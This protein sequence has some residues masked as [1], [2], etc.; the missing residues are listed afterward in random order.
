MEIG[1]PFQGLFTA[2]SNTV[3]SAGSAVLGG[4]TGYASGVIRPQ[5]GSPVLQNVT[6]Q[7]AQPK[8]SNVGTASTASNGFIANS[9]SILQRAG[10]SVTSA[11]DRIKTNV[12]NGIQSYELKKKQATFGNNVLTM[13]YNAVETVIGSG[14]DNLVKRL[15]GGGDNENPIPLRT[16]ETG[17]ITNPGPAVLEEK[18]GWFPSISD[19]L[20]L[21]TPSATQSGETVVIRE[22]GVEQPSGNLNIMPLL[23]LGGLGV[24]GFILLKKKK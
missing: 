11:L 10:S 17:S 19:I 3:K 16:I 7:V 12:T 8:P 24:G 5:T 13:G 14:L 21:G 1:N 23:L 9:V 15:T 4:M 20:A 2:V 22:T 18:T 6:K